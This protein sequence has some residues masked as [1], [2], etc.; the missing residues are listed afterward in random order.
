MNSPSVLAGLTPRDMSTVATFLIFAP[1]L[2]VGCVLGV[3][4]QRLHASLCE[5]TP[6]QG[7]Q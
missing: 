3:A 1:A 5:H 6:H 4:C 7:A 2:V